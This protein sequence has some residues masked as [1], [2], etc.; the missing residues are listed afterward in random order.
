MSIRIKFHKKNLW[1]VDYDPDDLS[2]I[3]GP[4]V[5]NVKYGSLDLA[6]AVINKYLR[7]KWVCEIKTKGGD[8]WLLIE[9][10]HPKKEGAEAMREMLVTLA[11]ARY[12]QY[13]E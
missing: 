6:N 10:A 1:F 8:G 5:S 4:F 11:Y 12:G 9:G 13:L 3:E 2:H 7:N